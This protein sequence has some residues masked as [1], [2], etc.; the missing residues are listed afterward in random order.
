MFGFI[1]QVLNVLNEPVHKNNI[2]KQIV[3][4]WFKS[5]KRRKQFSQLFVIQR[6]IVLFKSI[7]NRKRRNKGNFT[8]KSN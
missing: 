5:V 2:K 7:R 1:T 3:K 4:Y 8:S 6:K